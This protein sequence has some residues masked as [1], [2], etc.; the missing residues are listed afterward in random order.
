MLKMET[1]VRKIEVVMLSPPCAGCQ[2]GV[3]VA[4]GSTWQQTTVA[5][6]RKITNLGC[7]CGGC[8]YCVFLEL[9]NPIYVHSQINCRRS[10]V[11]PR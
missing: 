10:E 8:G 6:V 9:N 4:V 2:D 11:S 5:V 7:V 1:E 3:S